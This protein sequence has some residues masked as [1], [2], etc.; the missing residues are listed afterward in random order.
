MGRSYLE[1]I[2]ASCQ[3][4]PEGWTSLYPKGVRNKTSNM[5]LIKKFPHITKENNYYEEKHVS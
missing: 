1:A 4:T 5:G 3:K 2:H